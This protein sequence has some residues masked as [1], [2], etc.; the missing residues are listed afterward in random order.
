MH[1]TQKAVNHI[2]HDLLFGYIFVYKLTRTFKRFSVFIESIYG[3]TPYSR[4]FGQNGRQNITRYVRV[5]FVVGLIRGGHDTVFR[6]KFI[7]ETHTA[8]SA[9]FKNDVFKSR[10]YF[11]YPIDKRRRTPFKTVPERICLL[12]S[13]CSQI[14]IIIEFYIVRTIIFHHTPYGFSHII[15]DFFV[16]IIEKIPVAHGNFFTKTSYKTI[17]IVIFEHFFTLNADDLRL[18]PQPRFHSE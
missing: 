1:S 14:L 3:V 15:T 2:K 6:Q 4:L 12:I 17:V 7:I 13:S 8:R 11:S 16:T 9:M 18:N 10:F 5:F